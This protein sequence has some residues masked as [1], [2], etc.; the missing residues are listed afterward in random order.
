MDIKIKI[1]RISC[2]VN[3][4]SVLLVTGL[5]FYETNPLRAAYRGNT[6]DVVALLIFALIIITYIGNFYYGTRLAGSF[7]DE[8][9]TLKLNNNIRL[10]FYIFEI[11]VALFYSILIYY[12]IVRFRSR[13]FWPIRT[14]NLLRIISFL[15]LWAGYLSSLTRIFLTRHLLRQVSLQDKLHIERIGK[16]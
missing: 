11:I 10:T 15:C 5:I 9:I 12:L 4:M 1:Y 6:E 3:L 14:D 2:Y 7:T 13:L 16:E 8:L